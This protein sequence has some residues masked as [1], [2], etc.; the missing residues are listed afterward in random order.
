M[1]DPSNLKPKTGTKPVIKREEWNA[2]I[3]LAKQTGTSPNAIRGVGLNATR[4]I[5]RVAF[6]EWVATSDEEI[7]PWSVLGLKLEVDAPDNEHTP[8][9][10]EVGPIESENDRL[11]FTNLGFKIPENGKGIIQPITQFAPVRLAID[12][13]GTDPV[14][15]GMCG[16]YLGG[17]YAVAAEGTGLFCL[18][19][20]AT[21]GFATCIRELVGTYI[22][23]ADSPIA[24][25]SGS[26]PGSG[27]CSL[28]MWNGTNLVET[29]VTIKCYNLSSSIVSSG[30]FL[31]AK[32]I[33]GLPCIDFEAC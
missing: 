21:Q 18:A 32:T 27:N 26:T 14:E 13:S 9:T 30:K 10:V 11:L 5:G 12:E 23:K 2:L 22:V 15:G 24:A 25:L 20:D 29:D 4:Y 8:L 31:Q 33:Y 28:W 17:S 16:P 19:V 6:A 3:Q 7:P 1:P